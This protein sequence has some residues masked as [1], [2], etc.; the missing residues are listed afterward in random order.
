[1]GTLAFGHLQFRRQYPRARGECDLCDFPGG[2]DR[3]GCDE[4]MLKKTGTAAVQGRFAIRIVTFA[5][6]LSL[7][8]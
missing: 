6:P 1:L 8:D 7:S 4:K 3:Y 2:K 5:P